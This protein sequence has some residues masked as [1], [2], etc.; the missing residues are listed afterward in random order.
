MIAKQLKPQSSR[1]ELRIS[2]KAFKDKGVG[3][4]N[5]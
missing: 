4:V 2:L 1:W 3:F 5:Y